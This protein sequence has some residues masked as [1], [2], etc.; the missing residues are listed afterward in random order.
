[1]SMFTKEQLYTINN[2]A[3][4]TSLV[5][6][7]A[8]FHEKQDALFTLSSIRED[9]ISLQNLFIKFTVEDPTEVTFAETVFG[10]VEFWLNMR[11]ANRLKPDIEK[12]RKIA[13]V[14]RKQQAFEVILEAT[15][16]K[17]ATAYQAA[18]YL[19]EEPWKGKTAAA[20]KKANETTKEASHTFSG[21]IERLK[22][23]GLL[24]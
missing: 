14:K 23:E 21:D 15:K 20:K 1:M 2:V 5:Y 6:E 17:D 10:S 18:K 16:K 22:Q 11:E 8:K 4:T 24:Q 13:D 7:T 19:I 12:W 9:F 3:K